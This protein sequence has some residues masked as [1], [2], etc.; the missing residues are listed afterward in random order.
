MVPEVTEKVCPQARQRHCR[1]LGRNQC[2]STVPHSGQTGSPSRPHRT[3]RSSSK[4]RSSLKPKISRTD[5]E[6]AAAESRKWGWCMGGSGGWVD[7]PR[8]RP[9]VAQNASLPLTG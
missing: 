4:A 6:R 5:S 9:A 3:S 1:R 2:A 8:M 7:V